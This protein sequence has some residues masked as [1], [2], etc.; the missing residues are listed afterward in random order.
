MDVEGRIGSNPFPVANDKNL[1][2][3]FDYM[4]LVAGF[5]AF[6]RVVMTPGEHPRDSNLRLSTSRFE[7]ST[8]EGLDELDCPA[9]EVEAKE[10][11]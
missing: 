9:T 7:D 6:R 1:S 5:L 2:Q 11:S 8:S 4:A 3:I 10:G